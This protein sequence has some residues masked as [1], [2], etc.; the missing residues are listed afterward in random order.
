[1]DSEP[2]GPLKDD[3]G[4]DGATRTRRFGAKKAM[5]SFPGA[6]NGSTIRPKKKRR[7]AKGQN[8][9]IKGKE[10]RKG[11]GKPGKLAKMMELPIDII[12]EVM[13]ILLYKANF[14]IYETR[15]PSL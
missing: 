2:E 14:V 12:C 9:S 1:M 3:A 15:L 13:Y 7:T 4:L 6:I 10:R 8:S 11:R 5:R